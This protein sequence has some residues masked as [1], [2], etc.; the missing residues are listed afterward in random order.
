MQ[1]KL[2]IKL[3]IVVIYSKMYI[4][5]QGGRP[6]IRDLVYLIGLS[7]SITICRKDTPDGM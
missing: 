4:K 3:F 5:N 2:N 7:P 1:T 6:K